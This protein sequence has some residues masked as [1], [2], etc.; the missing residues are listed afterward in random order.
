MK[1]GGVEIEIMSVLDHK[2]YTSGR[3]F[4]SSSSASAP[5]A[6]IFKTASSSFQSFKPVSVGSAQ[7][8]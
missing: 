3:I 5:A 2:E 1:I 7:K 8:A 6:L 4:I